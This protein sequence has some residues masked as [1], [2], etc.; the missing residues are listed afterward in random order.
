LHSTQLTLPLVAAAPSSHRLLRIG[1]RTYTL[2]IAR[3]PRA[4]RYL[5]R[6]AGDGAVRLTVPR[7]AAIAAGLRFAE[8]QGAW[9]ERERLRLSRRLAPLTGGSIVWFRGREEPLVVTDREVRCGPESIVIVS[10]DVD[11]R[12]AVEAHFR[13]LAA[14]ELPPQC[15]ALARQHGLS[16][17]AVSVRNQQS[18]WGACSSHRVITLNWRLVQ[19]PPPV[20]EY[21][22]LHELMHLRQP[23][24]SRRFWREVDTVC[25]HWRASE[26]WLRTHGKEIL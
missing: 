20:T 9:I 1:N 21:I 2:R 6:V 11:V 25:P 13:K 7:G 4:R 12:S 15:L 5:L 26:R 10:P 22:V 3:H 8:R 16:V 24:H 23:N 14:A 18:R 19:M 17:A